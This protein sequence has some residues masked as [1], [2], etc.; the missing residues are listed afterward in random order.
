MRRNVQ[1]V[2]I[3]QDGSRT[4]RF[5]GVMKKPL[6]YTMWVL[7]AVLGLVAVTGVGLVANSH[8]KLHRLV[9]VNAAPVPYA[10]DTAA[11]ERGRYVYESRGCLACHGADGAG[12]VFV[13]HP[14]G[15][16]VRSANL[17]RGAGSAV[18]PYDE[19]DWVR[20]IR[21]GVKPDGRPVFVMPSEEYNR[22]TDAD[23]A[24]LVAYM[25]AL[26][27]RDAAGA[28]FKLPLL[29]RLV[30]GAGVM[31]DAAEKIDH[32][33]P[34][35]QPVPVGAT[36]EHGRYVAQSCI[37]C[38]GS[39]LRGGRIPGAPPEWPPAAD[40]RAADGPLQHYRESAQFKH[41]VRTGQRPD[42]T[43]ASRVMPRNVHMNDVDL[44]A[45]FVYLRS[46]QP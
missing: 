22:L 30:H 14:N 17:T 36:V 26:P 8:R 25:R 16:F 44:E 11:R 32:T 41:F 10:N 18:L 4:Q 40:L 35:A 3:V 21:H 7:G 29:V 19:R 9:A 2:A 33:L 24:D 38:H 42:G 34:P 39:Q 31:R 23:L 15:L 37:G 45:L 28:Q 46:P 1:L 43:S 6:K 5:N 20:A 12:R 27:P 13:D